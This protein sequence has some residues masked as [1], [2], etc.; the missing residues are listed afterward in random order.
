MASLIGY[1]RA[2]VLA[3]SL[4]GAAASGTATAQV[5]NEA[6]EIN[7]CVCLQQDVAA[8]SA[9]NAAKAQALADVERQLADLDA[10]LAAGR[11]RVDVN[12]PESVARYKAL[13]ERHD[14]LQRQSIGPVHDAAAQATARYNARADEYNRR[15]A[16]RPFSSTLTAQVQAHP[17]CP[18]A[19]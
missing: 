15:C 8:L 13:L 1:R 9:E 2:A 3:M 6:A 14:A 17:S 12:S 10:Q 19:Q 4:F 11:S 16:G 7:A 5:P 18:P